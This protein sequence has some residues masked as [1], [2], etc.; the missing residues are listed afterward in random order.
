MSGANLQ[1]AQYLIGTV[2]MSAGGLQYSFDTRL[3]PGAIAKVNMQVSFGIKNAAD[4]ASTLV[5]D[6][7]TSAAASGV[8]DC[9]KILSGLFPGASS[10]FIDTE[11]QLGTL[12]M[13]DWRT[14]LGYLNRRDFL[15]S[16]MV[17]GA[18]I[19]ASSAGSATAYE[20]DITFPMDLSNLSPDLG[21]FAQG[22]ERLK[23][24]YVQLATASTLTPT[25]ALTNCSVVISNFAIRFTAYT[26]SGS[27]GDVGP[28]WRALQ[29]TNLQLPYTFSELHRLAILDTTP[30]ATAQATYGTIN[31]QD[32]EQMQ[33]S[34]FGLLWQ[35]EYMA[36]Y[37]AAYDISKRCT[38]YIFRSPKFHF[39]EWALHAEQIKLQIPLLQTTNVFD[40]QVIAPSG[41][42]ANQ[43]AQQVGAGGPTSQAKVAPPSV[44]ATGDL[45]PTLHAL[46][47][48][49][50]LPG[51]AAVNG[52]S[53][54]ATPA[55]AGA[56]QSATLQKANSKRAVLA[57]AL[58]TNR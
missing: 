19:P 3:R 21:L 36:D 25:I 8:D 10:F 17:N 55:A 43:V 29:N 30:V 18:A 34:D 40:I 50:T 5:I 47:P 32:S 4:A 42:V 15:G 58:K 44:Q 49:R 14:I 53:T 57:A 1:L 45:S 11:T 16:F 7:G 33:P 26:N 35:Q 13:P 52:A 54:A 37:G 46:L 41:T 51:V 27:R 2:P 24:G 39:N 9:D 48:I 56:A 31:V 22:S 6:T 12:Q 23:T 28:S 38:P 20:I